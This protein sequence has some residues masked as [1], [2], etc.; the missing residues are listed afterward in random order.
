MKARNT[1][2][3]ALLIGL[4]PGLAAAVQTRPLRLELPALNTQ[5]MNTQT[6]PAVE[7]RG[8]RAL[9]ASRA[10]ERPGRVAPLF[11]RNGNANRAVV[12]TR[13]QNLG[14]QALESVLD[15][16]APAL[17]DQRGEGKLQL[18]FQ[19]QGNAFRDL[20]RSYREA[21]DRVSAKIWDEPN[22]KRVRFDVA[23]KPGLGVEIPIGKR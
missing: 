17:D 8:Q 7:A 10:D 18:K 21:C 19:K 9:F 12:Q 2:S 15:P 3:L 13:V 5:A 11:R 22:G 4:V 14:R 16:T 1:A 6:A 20:S 23:G